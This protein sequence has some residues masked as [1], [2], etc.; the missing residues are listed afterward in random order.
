MIASL[1]SNTLRQYNT[2]YNKWWKFCKGQPDEMFKPTTE[3]ILEFLNSEFIN[4][5]KYATLNTHR[6]ALNLI[7][8]AGKSDVVD[9]FL[10]GAFKLR[11]TFPR[12]ENI[13]DPQ[14]VLKYVEKLIPLHSLDLKD[15]TLKLIIL[16]ALG[17][18]QRVQTLAKIKISNI[19]KLENG[20]EISITDILKTSTPKKPQPKLCFPMFNQHPELCHSL[21]KHS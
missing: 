7:S 2:T 15:L 10:K 13:W 21:N 12:Y 14:Q 11:P 19:K 3:K 9:R 18:G 8:D 1:S 17:S 6:S 4:S 5:A 20:I 16:L